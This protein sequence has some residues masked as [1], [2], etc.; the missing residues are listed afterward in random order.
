MGEREEYG[1]ALGDL[2][3]N[4]HAKGGQMRLAFRQGLAG[5]PAADDPDQPYARVSRQ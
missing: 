1:V 4:R 2:L 5:T 3:A